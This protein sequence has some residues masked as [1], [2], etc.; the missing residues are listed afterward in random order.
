M[1]TPGEK[2]THLD[3]R[4]KGEVQ[5]EVTAAIAEWIRSH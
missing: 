5:T 1:K 4:E 3:Y 2:S